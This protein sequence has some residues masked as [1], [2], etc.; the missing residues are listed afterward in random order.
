MENKKNL[1]INCTVCD[2]RNV[3]EELLKVYNEVKINAVHIITSP[4]AQA[5]LGRYNVRLNCASTT[6]SN[7][8][9]SVSTINGPLTIAPDQ[10]MPEEKIYLL[11]NAPLEIL[12]GCEKVLKSYAGMTVNGLVTCPESMVGLLSSFNIN[13]PIRT[14]PDGSIVL[15]N[16]TVLN[17]VFYLRAKQNTLYYAA[18]QII[19]L[20]SDIDFTKLAEKNVRFATKRLLVS[21]SLAESA[22]PLFSEKTDIVILP[23]GCTCVDSDAELNATLF[24]RYG[25]EL[26]INGDLSITPNSAPLLDQISFLRVNGDLLVSKSLKDRVLTMDLEYNDLY[27]VG[28]VLITDRAQVEISAAMLERAED[29]LSVMNCA[30]VSI[31]ADVSPDLIQEKLVSIINC[32]MVSCSNKEQLDAVVPLARDVASLSLIDQENEDDKPANDENVVK[33]NSVFYT[34]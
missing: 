23:D 15:K 2:V 11:V 3:T 28:S 10:V 6:T 1:K 32:A 14:Y 29:G 34:F 5:L 4:E 33:I 26:Y 21:E 16:T 22:V 13:G 24:K 8:K 30:R 7:E 19:A 9:I 17:R 12:P 20:S 27:V 25:E 31:S 18:S